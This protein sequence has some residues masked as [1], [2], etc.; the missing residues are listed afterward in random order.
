MGGM[1]E[2][3]TF[4]V[5]GVPQGKGRPRF[6][7]KSRTTYTPANT[8]AYEATVGR[9]ALV[10][11]RGRDQFNGP[12]HMDLRAHMPIPAS[13]NKARKEAALLGALRPVGRPDI[14]NII[15][16]IADGLNGIAFADD[17][18]IVSVS[19]SKVYAAG[20]PFVCVTIK[21]ISSH[22]VPEIQNLDSPR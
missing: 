19:G 18:A 13:W 12:V 14:D 16:V 3:L 20:E 22:S 15:K 8:K 5:P 10:N 7:G 17:A 6:S 1:T 9:M 11:M 21:S 4:V 2:P